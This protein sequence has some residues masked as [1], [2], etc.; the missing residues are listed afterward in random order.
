MEISKYIS[1]KIKI[2]SFL[3]IIFVLFIHSTILNVEDYKAFAYTQSFFRT[4]FNSFYPLFFSISGFLF[5]N[6]FEEKKFKNK[7]KSRFKS[8]VMPYVFWNIFFL[9]IMLFLIYLPVTAPYM[10]S[11]FSWLF[12]SSI[13][14][15]LKEIFIV[16][17]GF[18]LW[19]I[20]D[21]IILVLLSPVIWLLLKKLSYFSILLFIVV[22][23]LLSDFLLIGA[24]VPFS[25]G[26]LLALKNVNL[27][28]RN[29]LLLFFLFLAAII[30]CYLD[31]T[32]IHFKFYVALVPFLFLWFLYDKIIDLGYGFHAINK[33]A[34]FTFFIYVFHE[35]TLNI[36]KK[37]IL[38]IGNQNEISVWLSYFLSPPLIVLISVLVGYI[39]KS[40]ANSIYSFMTGGR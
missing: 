8:L 27:I 6:N 36:F 10:N 34:T 14:D 29:N 9:L 32:N 3:G 31:I 39:L 33:C 38:R 5:F 1:K 40:K 23:Y 13:S 7:F 20:R 35:P 30:A 2:M 12:N 22:Q 26:G 17:V 19:F 4:L 25:M 15:I 18:H 24:I 16:P 11:D 37:V 28:Y 21:L